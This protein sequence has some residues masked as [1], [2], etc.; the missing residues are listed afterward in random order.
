MTIS[1]TVA[2]IFRNTQYDKFDERTPAGIHP[3]C[4]LLSEKTETKRNYAE[5]EGFTMMRDCFRSW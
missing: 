1:H 3:L 2:F 5:S 4:H